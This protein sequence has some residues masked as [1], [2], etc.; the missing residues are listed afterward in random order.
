MHGNESAPSRLTSLPSVC[1]ATTTV[2]GAFLLLPATALGEDQ[3]EEI[4]QSKLDFHF[5]APRVSLG[6]RGGWAFNR[7]D[8]EIYD[9][10]TET[11]TLEKN[12]FDA[13]AI[14]ADFSWRLRRPGGLLGRQRGP[15][16]RQR[17]HP[18]HASDPGAPDRQPQVLPHR[19]RAPGG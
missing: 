15:P 2:L 13:P 16:E 10:L 1:L 12:D 3:A 9:F 8:G 7:S 4:P 18:G 14:A 19:P 5:Q 6:L 11:L 17:D